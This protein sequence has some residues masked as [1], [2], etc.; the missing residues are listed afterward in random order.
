[1]DVA[2]IVTIFQINSSIRR[3]VAESWRG[4]RRVI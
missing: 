1:V 4:N 3:K 2:Q